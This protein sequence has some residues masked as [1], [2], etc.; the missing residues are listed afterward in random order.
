MGDLYSNDASPESPMNT[1]NSQR[2]FSQGC[3]SDENGYIFY[4]LTLTIVCIGLPLTLVAIF[5]VYSLIRKD[6]V[7]PIYVINLLI[8]D[9]IQLCCFIVLVAVN[10]W[11]MCNIFIYI[12]QFGMMISI[13]FMVVISMERYLM[14]A[15]PLWYRFRRNIKTSVVVSVVVWMLP[16][17][18]LPIFFFAHDYMET[19][20]ACFLLIQF[21]L[22]LFFL[23]GTLRALSAARSVAADEKRRVVATLVL[24][25]FSY[26]LLFL[27]RI[28]FSLAKRFRKYQSFELVTIIPVYFTPLADLVLYVFMKK[29][30]CDKLL[31]F[32]CCC[33]MDHDDEHED[34]M[35]TSSS[36]QAERKE[37]EKKYGG[38]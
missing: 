33:K 28:I 13:C 10:D 26:T 38:V 4:V 31:A 3:Y 24:V 14:M 22:L 18:Y 25:L 6:H 32:L 5:A 34:N 20:I 21:P 37:G 15:W 11:K 8:S 1:L 19:A 29:G 12:L 36:M 7:A 17:L 35:T 9:V 16:L 30:I 2:R 23:G 27:P